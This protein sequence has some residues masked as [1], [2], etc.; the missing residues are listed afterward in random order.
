MEALVVLLG[1]LGI[2]G[3]IGYNMGYASAEDD[4][5]EMSTARTIIGQ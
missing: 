1:G 4:I 5:E 2:G 3:W